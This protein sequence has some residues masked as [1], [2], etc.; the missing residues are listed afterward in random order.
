MY[1]LGPIC[2]YVDTFNFDYINQYLSITQSVN[3]GQAMSVSHSLALSQ[4]IVVQTPFNI[5]ISQT[6][7]P[8]QTVGYSYGITVNDSLGI[9]QQLVLPKTSNVSV[10]QTLFV[11][12]QC[13]VSPEYNVK[14]VINIVQS[15]QY[16]YGVAN[17]QSLTLTDT[18]KLSQNLSTVTVYHTPIVH[19]LDIVQSV[20]P[21][22]G[23][24]DYLIQTLNFRDVGVLSYNR[25]LALC[26]CIPIKQ[27]VGN[28]VPLSV[29]QTL[30]LSWLE[31]DVTYQHLF[32]TQL[33]QTNADNI[34]CCHPNG[35][36][37]SRDT[38]T[39]LNVLQSVDCTMTYNVTVPQ[40]LNLL[41]AVAWR[42]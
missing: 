12:Q 29:S 24:N 8:T 25:Y 19:T 32:L 9:L 22:V 6:L 11:L 30:S 3:F 1:G 27:I 21:A 36:N 35:N 34:T 7:T 33:I 10:S 41:T 13:Y 26:Q 39:N 2:G 42:P 17:T 38:S 37:G 20:T 15:N 40:Q 14:Q 16:A 4:T 28:Y 31:K 18:N 5:S 23:Y